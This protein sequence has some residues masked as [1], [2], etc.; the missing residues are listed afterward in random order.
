MS[1][2]TARY[3]GIETG[4]TKIVCAVGSGPGNLE[5]EVRFPTTTPPENIAQI[6]EFFRS[7]NAQVPLSAIGL[8]AFGPLDLNPASP[9]YGYVT[10]TN[11]LDWINTD[12]AGRLERLLSIPIA[13]DTDVNG[14][15]LGEYYWG[16]GQDCESLVYITIGTGIGVGV[17]IQGRPLHGLVH[18]EGGHI[19]VPH[20]RRLDPFD[21]CCA[22]HGDCLEGLASGTA[23]RQRWDCP[24]ETLPGDHPAWKLEAD[25]I[26]RALHSLIL[27]L[28][29]NRVIL[30]GSVMKQEQLYPL[31]RQQVQASL[32]G[33][34]RSPAILDHIH[35]YIVPPLLGGQA[36]VLG[37]I[38]LAQN[39]VR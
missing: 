26:A 7:E 4:G 27:T 12:L 3:G 19:L 29:P 33:Y 1:A 18:P 34:F 10:A 5:A 28:S 39:K 17:V 13:F 2:S 32:H 9:T 20:D 35:T 16:A 38:A 23:L 37:A 14:A 6:V 15:A 21:G 36:G 24:A 8:A 11:K 30:G 31:V 22:Y 25:Y